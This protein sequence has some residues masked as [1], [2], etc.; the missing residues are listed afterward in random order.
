MMTR[1]S[2]YLPASLHQRL[3]M[4]SK[5]Q[6]K[7]LSQVAI[8]LLDEGLSVDEDNKQDDVYR[9]LKSIKGVVK[10]ND[11]HASSSIDETVYGDKGAWSGEK[12]DTGLW[13]LP[14]N[15]QSQ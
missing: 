14:D 4:A 3:Q 12:S 9:A 15:P 5:R 6:R 13:E 7:T 8:E 1:T 10:D 11:P 2:L